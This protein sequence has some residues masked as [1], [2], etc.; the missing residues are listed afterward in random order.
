MGWGEQRDESRVLRLAPLARLWAFGF[1]LWARPKAQSLKAK[2]S[3]AAPR[4]RLP[5]TS[6]YFT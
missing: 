1:R 2:A 5:R 6:N 4:S 3:Q